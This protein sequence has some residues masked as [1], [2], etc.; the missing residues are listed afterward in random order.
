[1][2]ECSHVLYG[3]LVALATGSRE[4]VAI[5][6]KELTKIPLGFLYFGDPVISPRS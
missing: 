6:R 2:S 4:I 3:G 1:V 5:L